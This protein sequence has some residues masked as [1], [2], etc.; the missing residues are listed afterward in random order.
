MY[1]L[2]DARIQLQA[3]CNV[4]SLQLGTAAAKAQV[5]EAN[6]SCTGCGADQHKESERS[7]KV[8]IWLASEV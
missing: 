8:G 6:N 5:Q 2:R 4:A 3:S 7:W 1:Q